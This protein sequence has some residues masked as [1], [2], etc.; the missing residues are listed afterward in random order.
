[1]YIHMKE[2]TYSSNPFQIA[3]AVLNSIS[4]PSRRIRSHT[5]NT[6]S[7][8]R[9]VENRVR[10]HCIVNTFVNGGSKLVPA[11]K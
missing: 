7:L 8:G 4:F 10:N 1:M 6:V 11:K 2:S 3:R 9:Q 5:R